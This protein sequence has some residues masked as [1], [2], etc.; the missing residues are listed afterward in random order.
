MKVF[1]VRDIPKGADAQL[2]V[3]DNPRHRHILKNYRRHG[4][5]EVSGR[6]REILDPRMTAE[7]PV[8][9]MFEGGQYRVLD[10]MDAVSG[11]YRSITDDKLNV[12]GPLEED[13]AVTDDG[14]F[15]EAVFARVV[16][17]DSPFVTADDV[18]PTKVYQISSR[19][20]MR[21]PYR[22]GRLAGEHV[23]E[24]FLSREVRE[25]DAIH[26]ISPEQARELLT[27]LIDETPLDE[28]VEGLALF[29][30]E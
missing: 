9:R 14:I 18:E 20:V 26:L 23:Y 29:D 15:A 7:H 28:I 17:G 1:D 8:Y 11:F 25:V 21:W 4:L 19:I 10:G 16:R 22:G 13:V 2:R 30:Q 12:F 27:P 3:V 6:W 5:L 24:N